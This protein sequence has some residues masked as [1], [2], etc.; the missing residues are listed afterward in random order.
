[1]YNDSRVTLSPLTHDRSK[2]R[3]KHQNFR[4]NKANQPSEEEKENT[5]RT[6]ASHQKRAEGKKFKIPNH[7]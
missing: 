4:S 7:E 2:K 5:R 6:T 3:L 1:M